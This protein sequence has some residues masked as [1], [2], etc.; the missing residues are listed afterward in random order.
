MDESTPPRVGLSIMH[1]FPQAQHLLAPRRICRIPEVFAGLG[2]I[3]CCSL[4]CL[5]A[6]IVEHAYF[7]IDSKTTDTMCSSENEAHI[8]RSMTTVIFRDILR[9]AILFK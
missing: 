6:K 3:S 5:A 4:S 8:F 1:I 2:R 9:M 7:H